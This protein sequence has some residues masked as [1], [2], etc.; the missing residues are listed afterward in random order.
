MPTEKRVRAAHQ[1]ISLSSLADEEFIIRAQDM[2]FSDCNWNDF[3][4]DSF[5]DQR[6]LL[7]VLR[8][9]LFDE[10]GCDL[11]SL[12]HLDDYDREAVIH[13]LGIAYTSKEGIENG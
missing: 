11:A 8:A 12:R 5:D 9:I 2:N 4:K 1:L 3:Y 7:D 6:I 13:G 10:P